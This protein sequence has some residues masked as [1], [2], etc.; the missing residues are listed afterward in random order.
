MDGIQSWSSFEQ[1]QRNSHLSRSSA[2]ATD[3]DTAG[4]GINALYVSSSSSD[5]APAAAS[6]LR[7]S[8][9]TAPSSTTEFGESSSG[10]VELQQ[11][12]E[13][14][15]RLRFHWMRP[16]PSLAFALAEEIGAENTVDGSI[17]AEKEKETH[18][19]PSRIW[20]KR[21]INPAVESSR[22]MEAYRSSQINKQSELNSNNEGDGIDGQE[23]G[24]HNPL[25]EG[26]DIEPNSNNPPT[27]NDMNTK[28]HNFPLE[29]PKLRI[30]LAS[31]VEP[32]LMSSWLPG[33]DMGISSESEDEGDNIDG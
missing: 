18:H 25:M 2:A 33:E 28:S 7:H 30:N 3:T 20:V 1:R 15:F 29:L 26:S 4:P 31:L 5:V 10:D 12:E 32:P 22:L 24:N 19:V 13:E 6:L 27:K 21:E 9:L 17:K 8:G 14:E 11:K 23:E 16:H